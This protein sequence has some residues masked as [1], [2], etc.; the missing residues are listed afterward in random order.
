M[1]SR[2]VIRRPIVF[3]GLNICVFGVQSNNRGAGLF[4]GIGVV[5][6]AI[7][8]C[9]FYGNRVGAELHGDN[10]TLVGNVFAD[11]LYPNGLN[12][13]VGKSST[14]GVVVGNFGAK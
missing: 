5:G 14:G 1:P 4:V 10:F 11:P 12:L 9:K 7:T 3:V 8:G 13:V 2:W 6:A